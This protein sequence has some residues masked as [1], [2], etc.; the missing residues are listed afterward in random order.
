MRIKHS[1]MAPGGN[2]KVLFICDTNYAARQLSV[3]FSNKKQLIVLQMAKT[4][5]H[6]FT[7]Q[8]LLNFKEYKLF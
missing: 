5:K 4:I 7:V 2:T 3:I 6:Q 1:Y 8:I